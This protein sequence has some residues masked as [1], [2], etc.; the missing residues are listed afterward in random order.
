[1]RGFD[2]NLFNR[3]PAPAWLVGINLLI[4]VVLRLTAAILHLSGFDALQ[5]SVL[6]WVELPGSP[7]A[8]LSRPWTLVTYMFSQFEAWHLIFNMLMLFWIGQLFTLAYGSRRLILLYIVGGLA[9][10]VVFIAACTLA[11]GLNGDMLLTGSSASVFAILTATA[12][13]MPRAPIN[14]VLLGEIQLRWVVISLIVIDLC[15]G[16]GGDNFGG[17]LAHLG[18]VAT[19]IFYPYALKWL[20]VR[21]KKGHRR[22][23]SS[24]ADTQNLDVILDKIK[25]SGYAS[26]TQE[27]RK[28]LFEISSRIK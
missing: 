25:M 9:G 20:A 27:E 17:H 5:Q 10:A 16:A 22:V 28:R 8:L 2:R 14:L 26:L 12:M 23:H 19:G 21:K 15:L 6:Q 7:S 24:Q 3:F 1:M 11:P 18:G 4:F 13:L